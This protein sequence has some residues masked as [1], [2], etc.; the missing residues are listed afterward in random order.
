MRW[1]T[2]EL[3]FRQLLAARFPTLPMLGKIFFACPAGSSTSLFQE[4]LESEMDVPAELLFYGNS[5]VKEAHNACTGYR[6][7]AVVVMPGRYNTE[8]DLT[9]SKQSTHLLGMGQAT[10]GYYGSG[11]DVTIRNLAATDAAYGMLM[12]GSYN[13]VHGIHFNNFGENAACVSALKEQGRSNFYFG[14]LFGGMTRSQQAGAAAACCLWVDT[15][16]VAAGHGMLLDGCFVGHSGGYTRSNNNTLLLFGATGA[17]SAG[18]DVTLRN[19]LFNTRSKVAGCSAIKFAAN[20]TVD[21]M[22]LIDNCVFYNFY[23]EN[24]IT[25]TLTEVINDDCGTT[26]KILVKDS[27]QTGWASWEATRSTV[28]LTQ[29]GASGASGI[30]T[31]ET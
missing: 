14:C 26:H 19:T 25:S 22:F 1:Q 7:D 18:C 16:V 10:R 3:Y 17:V 23:D 29:A 6:N 28:Y 8:G 13:Q 2:Q 9:W 21:R 27:H 30:A 15:S 24:D 5:A 4:W 20:Y 31:V 11:G 12:T